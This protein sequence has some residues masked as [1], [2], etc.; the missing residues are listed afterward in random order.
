[1]A[2][3]PTERYP[4]PVR[5][6]AQFGSAPALGAGGPRFES[7]RPDQPYGYFPSLLTVNFMMGP[8]EISTLP[9]DMRPTRSFIRTILV[10][11][12]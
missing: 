9:S 1:M 10:I 4:L 7:G 12:T 6:V 8:L 11:F 3:T 2:H 5:G